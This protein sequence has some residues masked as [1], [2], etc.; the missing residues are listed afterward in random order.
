MG[1]DGQSCLVLDIADSGRLSG[2]NKRSSLP[3]FSTNSAGDNTGNNNNNNIQ[4][5][6]TSQN[7]KDVEALGASYRSS[8]TTISDSEGL[9]ASYRQN[10]RRNSGPKNARGS[11]NGLTSSNSSNVSR[12][13]KQSSKSDGSTSSKNGNTFSNTSH[14]KKSFSSGDESLVSA[15]DNNSNNSKSSSSSKTF[16]P[17]NNERPKP[18]FTRFNSSIQLFDATVETTTTTTTTN[19]IVLSS[20]S[21]SADWVDSSM[22]SDWSTNSN[23]TN[24][25]S[26][27]FRD[28]MREM[29]RN[30][31]ASGQNGN[32]RKSTARRKSSQNLENL[33]MDENAIAEALEEVER[34]AERE[35]H[36][37]SIGIGSSQTLPKALERKTLEEHD[38]NNA[39]GSPGVPNL[40]TNVFFNKF[41]GKI[42]RGKGWWNEDSDSSDGESSLH[43][44][45][46]ATSVCPSLA[47]SFKTNTKNSFDSAKTS[48]LSS[49]IASLDNSANNSLNPSTVPSAKNSP[50]DNYTP[51]KTPSPQDSVLSASNRSTASH[52]L[53]KVEEGINE[54]Y[55]RKSFEKQQRERDERN[56]QRAEIREN[57][58]N[59]VKCVVEK[60]YDNGLLGSSNN[61]TPSD[62][63]FNANNK[64]DALY[65]THKEKV[66]TSGKLSQLAERRRNSGNSAPNSR[67]KLIGKS[68]SLVTDRRMFEQDLSSSA[69]NST[70]NNRITASAKRPPAFLTESEKST[71]KNNNNINNSNLIHHRA[72]YAG[73]TDLH[74]NKLSEHKH[75]SSPTNRPPRPVREVKRMKVGVF[76]KVCFR[77][78]IYKHPMKMFVLFPFFSLWLINLLATS[79]YLSPEHA[80]AF[81]A[82]TNTAKILA[83]D[84]TAIEFTA[85]D[86]FLP[87]WFYR[88]SNRILNNFG[89]FFVAYLDWLFLYYGVKSWT[90]PESEGWL[91]HWYFTAAYWGPA[92]ILS[93][94]WLYVK[95]LDRSMFAGENLM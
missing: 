69:K 20:S 95:W 85:R 6:S 24:M 52:K 59:K 21:S 53:M 73:H 50:S 55:K 84:I 67:E 27:E 10:G 4:S 38:N 39:P 8:G 83:T 61:S 15:N 31:A 46:T 64:M 62:D 58:L 87:K 57:R 47:N 37:S 81:N 2:T 86:L 74:G 36:T 35:E 23:S 30:S 79:G 19:R 51:S 65:P 45:S 5:P 76:L 9:G 17:H 88:N 18:G 14:T 11:G 72:S 75:A 43:I 93:C 32:N 94:L 13:S 54:S 41:A 28:F 16:D 68:H 89:F 29:R 44:S 90:R 26:Q 80:E 3:S 66:L 63:F 70:T 22:G 25:G 42:N 12:P 71:I 48:S 7:F 92:L 1:R 77:Y 34:E 40:L 49:S 82:T 60:P 91:A 78:M 56:R 33:L